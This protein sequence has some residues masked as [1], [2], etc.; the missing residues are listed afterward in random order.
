MTEFL[1]SHCGKSFKAYL[2]HRKGVRTFC[3]RPCH[4]KWMVG[5][6]FGRRKR[7]I[8]ICKTC[9]KEFSVIKAR[10]DSAIYCSKQCWAVGMRGEK[11]Q[12][13]HN[14]INYCKT[15]N[16]AFRVTNGSKGKKYCSMPCRNIGLRGRIPGN[17]KGRE[18]KPCPTCKIPFK[19]VS[20]YKK[21]FCSQECC[22]KYI[23]KIN[24][25]IVTCIQCKKEFTH[26]KSRKRILCSIQCFRKYFSGSNSPAWRGGVSTPNEL[27][28]KSL[29]LKEW[30]Q[31]CIKRDNY[32][33][34]W[35]KK[36]GGKLHVDHIKPFAYYPELRFDINNGRT[37]CIECHA[38]KTKMDSRVF[39]FHKGSK[40]LSQ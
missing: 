12:R 7:V 37:L 35:C 26:V 33:C 13:R 3:S 24:R 30:N 6:Y 39:E 17:F 22:I 1:C 8:I 34:Q 31:F 23:M 14:I 9:K 15:C 5:K 19:Q 10:K 29:K 25:L 2:R 4:N 16:S 27:V 40:V 21:K 32:T 36:Q 28:R 20:S 11:P 38:W 18:V